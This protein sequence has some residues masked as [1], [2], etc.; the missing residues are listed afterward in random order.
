MKLLV[1]GASGYVGNKCIL[2]ALRRNWQVTGVYRNT[3]YP[4]NTTKAREN[5]D[6]IK[7]AQILNT[8]HNTIEYKDLDTHDSTKYDIVLSCIG[9]RSGDKK[10]CDAVD[11]DLNILLL[12]KIRPSHKY[13]LLSGAC[14]ETPKIPLQFSKL[15]SE[16]A[17]IDSGIPYTIVRP[18]CYYKCFVRMLSRPKINTLSEGVDFYP[19]DGDD[20]AKELINICADSA[21]NNIIS[22]GGDKKYNMLSIANEI[23]PNSAWNPKYFR[24]LQHIPFLPEKL[25]NTLD[26]VMYYNDNEMK[27]DKTINTCSISEYM[28]KINT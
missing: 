25:K 19:I 28:K 6:S 8:L 16:N 27:F 5:T 22:I 26:T 13:V 10:D 3:S 7:N 14:V 12:D 24:W 20:L 23:G 15:K 1:Y 21:T 18:T 4:T 17:L 2:E 11:A 9:A